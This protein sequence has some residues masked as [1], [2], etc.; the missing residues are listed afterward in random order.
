MSGRP[1][2]VVFDDLTETQLIDIFKEVGPVVSF[3][4]VFDRDTGKPKGYGF[5]TF[6]DAETAAS[7][8]RNLNNYD[9][10]G[11]QLRIDFA[12]SDKED[13][14][15][16]GNGG[17]GQGPQSAPQSYQQHQQPPPPQQ[18]QL[19]QQMYG[20]QNMN[21]PP[22]NTPVP[23][24]VAAGPPATDVINKILASYPPEQM[25]EVLAQMKLHVQS[26]P[27]QVQALLME[28]PQLSYALFQALLVMNVV[29]P[30]IMQRILQTQAITPQMQGVPPPQQLGIPPSIPPMM[31]PAA[32]IQGLTAA[33]IPQQQPQQQFGRPLGIPAGLPAGLGLPN[34]QPMGG[35]GP[36]DMVQEQQKQVLLQLLNLTPDQLQALPADQREKITLLR[37]QILGPQ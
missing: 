10:N 2:R 28:N 8:V 30:A 4:L 9:V 6:Q 7:A 12:E 21:T 20:Q 29:D 33:P 15:P 31:N 5:C 24:P 36:I 22:H 25:L 32:F 16:G 3:R 26:N 27:D 1:T 23:A 18:Q 14:G 37:T 11:R 13:P 17:P 34:Q 19:P 35:A